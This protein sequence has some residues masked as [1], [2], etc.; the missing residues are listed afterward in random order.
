MSDREVTLKKLSWTQLLLGIAAGLVSG[1]ATQKM[2]SPALCKPCPTADTAAAFEFVTIQGPEVPLKAIPL[3][4]L[5]LSLHEALREW[6]KSGAE[7]ST[8]QLVFETSSNTS[9]AQDAKPKIE[10]VLNVLSGFRL[11]KEPSEAENWVAIAPLAKELGEI[12]TA[13]DLDNLAQIANEGLVHLL[14]S[15]KT[16]LDRLKF[17]I[18]GINRTNNGIPELKAS[19]LNAIQTKNWE[20]LTNAVKALVT[21][22]GVHGGDLKRFVAEQQLESASDYEALAKQQSFRKQFET[23]IG[24]QK[25][26]E[27][28]P[29]LE[30]RYAN[31]DAAVDKKFLPLSVDLADKLTLLFREK[32]IAIDWAVKGI[33]F[34]AVRAPDSRNKID[35]LLRSKLDVL[36]KVRARSSSM[37][38]IRLEN[39]I[40]QAMPDERAVMLRK[41]NGTQCVI[42][43]TAVFASSLGGIQLEDRDV[44]TLLRWE[45][46]PLGTSNEKYDLERVL[47][48]TAATREDW[49]NVAI[50]EANLMGLRTQVYFPIDGVHVDSMP[51]V[52]II[53]QDA[54]FSYS[55]LTALPILLRSN[56]MMERRIRGERLIGR[57]KGLAC[58]DVLSTA[59]ALR[60]TASASPTSPVNWSRSLFRSLGGAIP[61]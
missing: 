61:K 58:E 10:G 27:L 50:A 22:M 34:A 5:G 37:R 17:T 55:N 21:N 52:D 29:L 15:E 46:L 42:P 48:A 4:P 38:A 11:T 28:S 23:S 30:P 14:E 12:L 60:R 36:P 53:P 26:V 59:P 2:T 25:F 45:Q 51:P 7:I 39:S 8:P 49:H 40:D 35:S 3:G 43:M 24:G 56:A 18:D 13:D 16:P 47:T 32:N 33:A 57:A 44:I 54:T 19:A 20:E 1:C 9:P 31:F 6:L 41:S